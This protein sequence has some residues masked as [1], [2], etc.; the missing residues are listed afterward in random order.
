MPLNTNQ[1]KVYIVTYE[2]WVDGGDNRA[3]W[4]G[5]TKKTIV[6]RGHKEMIE[7]CADIESW[8]DPKRHNNKIKNIKI[9]EV[10]QAVDVTQGNLDLGK[11]FKKLREDNDK[12]IRA[13][14]LRDEADRIEKGY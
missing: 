14:K 9:E 5:Y 7:W 2:G 13:Q 11:D 4:S 1:N 3:G 6:I 12:K 10:L 8:N